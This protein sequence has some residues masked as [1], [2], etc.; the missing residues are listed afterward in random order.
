M[1]MPLYECVVGSLV[2]STSAQGV[3]PRNPRVQPE[4]YLKGSKERCRAQ[5]TIGVRFFRTKAQAR[6]GT[7]NLPATSDFPRLPRSRLANDC[8]WPIPLKNS[9]LNCRVC[10][11]G[12]TGLAVSGVRGAATGVICSRSALKSVP[13]PNSVLSARATSPF[14]VDFAR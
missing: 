2:R 4:I 5:P 8:L 1:D 13:I 9:A 14:V 12:W 11:S 6:A 7:M 10:L 3:T